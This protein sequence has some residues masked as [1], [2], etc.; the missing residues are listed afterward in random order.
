MSLP[1]EELEIK[2]EWGHPAQRVVFAATGTHL[3]LV[4]FGID[5]V[6]WS[7][8]NTSSSV[9]ANINI[10]DGGDTTGEIVFPITLA[11]NE[12]IRDWFP[13]KGVWFNVG[14]TVNVTAGN[15]QGTVFY[16]HRR[17]H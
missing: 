10:L 8:A 1:A 14:L 5:L 7:L 15:V 6:G 13:E 4:Q 17:Q 12:S 16:R 2:V 11:A 3:V 9:A